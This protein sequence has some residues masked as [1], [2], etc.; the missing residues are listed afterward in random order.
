M[1]Q[2]SEGLV[3]KSMDRTKNLTPAGK[4]ILHTALVNPKNIIISPIDVKLGLI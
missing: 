1:G 3:Y 4:N 2:Q